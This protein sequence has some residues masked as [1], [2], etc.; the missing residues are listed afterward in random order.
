[1]AHLL[2][3]D[4]LLL[5]LDDERGTV[6][7]V[8]IDLRV[9]LGAA[10]LAEL[11]LEGAVRIDEPASRWHAARVEATGVSPS[12]PVLADALA[13]VAEK[14]RTV[15]DLAN[16]AG[17]GLR[18]RLARRLA[19]QG[20]LERHD[21][22]VLGLF[23]RTRWPAADAAHETEVR[24]TLRG[25]LLDERVPDARTAVLAGVLGALDRIPAVLGLHGADARFAK[26]RAKEIADGDW[27]SKAV[28]DAVRSAAAATTAAVTAA[29]VAA[30]SA[31]A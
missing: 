5:L 20:I 10:V 25:V 29:T 18:D 13:I 9:P 23:P 15:A 14:P 28:R 26:R 19:D 16:R 7:G 22:T 4:L 24:A 30:T 6:R 1:M 11:A 31:G 21:D 27:A 3:E 12:D 8:T 17:K 2:A